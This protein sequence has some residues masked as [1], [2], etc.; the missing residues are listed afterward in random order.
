MCPAPT[1]RGC[2]RLF[3]SQLDLFQQIYPCTALSRHLQEDKELLRVRMVPQ[4]LQHH[5]LDANSSLLL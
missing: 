2:I 3:L 4:W 1:E 5:V